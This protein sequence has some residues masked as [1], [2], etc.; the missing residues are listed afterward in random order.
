MNSLN[1]KTVML[2]I[3]SKLKILKFLIYREKANRALAKNM[4]SGDW[5]HWG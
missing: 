3:S 1:Y 4:G 5:I 2:K